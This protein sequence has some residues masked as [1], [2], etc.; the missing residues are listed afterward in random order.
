MSTK[1]TLLFMF[2]GSVLTFFTLISSGCNQKTLPGMPERY[3]ASIIVTQDGKPLADAQVILIN[4]DSSSN[5]SGGG[6]TDSKGVVRLRTLGQFDGIPEGT[7]KVGVEKI[8]YPANIVIPSE[9]PYGDKDA[10]KEYNRLIKEYENN[11]FQVVNQ[12]FS[13]DSSPLQITISKKNLHVTVDVS[14]AIRIRYQPPP[15]G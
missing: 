12:K 5:W 3:S 6:N 10:M 9:I 7:Y 14:P 15:K 11:T 8:E 1:K 13:I 4:I 2:L